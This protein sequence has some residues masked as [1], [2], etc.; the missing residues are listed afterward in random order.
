MPHSRYKRPLAQPVAEGLTVEPNQ[1]SDPEMRN[2]PLAHH[3][4]NHLHR[5]S[6]HSRHLFGRERFLSLFEL[7]RQIHLM[8]DYSGCYFQCRRN[9]QTFAHLFV[10]LRKC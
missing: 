3:L 1:K 4:V 8:T 2:A 9:P 7:V 6:K 10:A 5:A